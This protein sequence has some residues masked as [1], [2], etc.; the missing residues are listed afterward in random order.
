MVLKYILFFI[1]VYFAVRLAINP[2]LKSKDTPKEVD[3]QHKKLIQLRDIGVIDNDELEKFIEAY[4]QEKKKTENKMLYEQ[5]KQVL[6]ELK[7]AGYLN[8]E[9]YS[10]KIKILKD[11]LGVN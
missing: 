10:S 8:E 1:V 6:S 11:I 9:E 2:L 4:D 3:E 7:E 5:S